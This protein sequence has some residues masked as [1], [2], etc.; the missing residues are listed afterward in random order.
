MTPRSLTT[1]AA[2][3]SF[4]QILPASTA[5]SVLG[6]WSDGTNTLT[7]RRDGSVVAR[8]LGKPHHPGTPV[9]LTFHTEG[10]RVVVTDRAGQQLVHQLQGGFLRSP[11][12]ERF[13]R[14]D[15]LVVVF[16]F[17]LVADGSRHNIKIVRCE[18]PMDQHEI[19][20]ALTKKDER[21]GIELMAQRKFPIPKEYVGTTRYDFILFDSHTRTYLPR[22]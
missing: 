16:G 1:L 20:G 2:L 11:N 21:K 5:E 7:F 14:W 10:D 12:G 19:K 22:A 8:P 6:R 4:A 18:D 17:T 13:K 9:T 15:L 3:I